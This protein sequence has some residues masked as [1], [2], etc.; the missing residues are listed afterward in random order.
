MVA[1]TGDPRM[2][3]L[4]GLTTFGVREVCIVCVQSTGVEYRVCPFYSFW[5]VRF[6]R[7]VYLIIVDNTT[8][9]I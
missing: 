4:D 5:S 3:I 8:L 7:V 9:H 2:L 1:I 6:V